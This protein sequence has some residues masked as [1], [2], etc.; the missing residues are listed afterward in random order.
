MALLY[1]CVFLVS[2][3]INFGSSENDVY[4]VGKPTLLQPSRPYDHQL[5]LHVDLSLLGKSLIRLSSVQTVF[6]H[7]RKQIL[8][9]H[10]YTSSRLSHLIIGIISLLLFVVGMVLIFSFFTFNFFICQSLI[11]DIFLVVVSIICFGFSTFC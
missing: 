7:S 4:A 9:S 2:T 5:R 11:Y 3:Y 1:P 8:S 6:N 10:L